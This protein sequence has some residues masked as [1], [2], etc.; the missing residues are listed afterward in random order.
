M[1]LGRGII[2]VLRRVIMLIRTFITN[3]AEIRIM[4]IARFTKGIL[5]EDAI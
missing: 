2:I 4:Q 1:F 5:Q 3:T